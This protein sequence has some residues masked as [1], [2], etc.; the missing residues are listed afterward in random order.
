MVYYDN[1]STIFMNIG[2]QLMSKIFWTMVGAQGEEEKSIMVANSKSIKY[3]LIMLYFTNTAFVVEY[4][5]YI[6]TSLGALSSLIISMVELIV[7]YFIHQFFRKKSKTNVLWCCLD[8][9]ILFFVSIIYTVQNYSLHISGDYIS[10]LAIENIHEIDLV[11]SPLLIILLVCV[12]GTFLMAIYFELKYGEKQ[13]VFEKST[14]FLYVFAY[15]L[16]I[17]FNNNLL[18]LANT[19]EPP[20]FSFI[21]NS[22]TAISGKYYYK[23]FLH[24]FAEQ[25][26]NERPNE[27]PFCKIDIYKNDIIEAHTKN[28]IIFFVEGLSAR[29]IGAYGCRYKELTPNID[30]FANHAMVVYNYY[31]HT[32][33][34]YRGLLG[35]LASGYPYAVE[36]DIERTSGGQKKNMKEFEKINYKTLPKILSEQ[37]YRTFFL[38]PVSKKTVFY[39][40]SNYLGFDSV[41]CLEDVICN[42]LSKKADIYTGCLSDKSLLDSLSNFIQ[43]KDLSHSVEKFFLAVYNNGTHAFLDADASGVKYGDGK[44]IVLNRVHN[45]DFQFGKFYDYYLSSG[46][47]KTT[48]LIVTADHATFPEPSYTILMNDVDYKKQF[49]DKIPLIISSNCA[50]LPKSIDA[51]GRNS[52]DLAPT[53]CQIIGVN[54]VKNSFLGRSIFEPSSNSS[55]HISAIGD[56]F[57]LTDKNNVYADNDMPSSFHSVYEQLK[58]YVMSYYRDE[59]RNNIFPLSPEPV[60]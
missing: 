52:L 36:V 25:P 6:K 20:V 55:F 35:Q 4:V 37:G 32:A 11:L 19:W 2:Q 48:T 38:S 57:Y 33:A 22:T 31:N 43:Q 5:Y 23:Q 9:V 53:I 16:C 51:D 17:Y 34:T 27:Y 24:Y 58:K 50:D 54:K 3:Y 26:K 40:F 60:H 21:K 7:I 41:L 59:S 44:N 15:F 10:V 28:I 49:V 14:F 18:P 45:F 42:Y 8:Y 13:I 30:N 1:L 12:W 39:E 56:S 29:L 47:Y 46:L